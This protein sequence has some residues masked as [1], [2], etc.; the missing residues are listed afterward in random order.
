MGLRGMLRGVPDLVVVGEA[1]NG[2]AAQVLCRQLMPDVVLLDVRMPDMNGLEVTRLIRQQFPAIHVIIVSMYDSPDHLLQAIRAGAAGYL[3]KDAT[4]YELVTTI[5]QVLAGTL[6]ID[7]HVMGQLLRRADQQAT[8]QDR[9]VLDHLTKRE[10]EVWQLIAKG[11]TNREIAMALSLS[12]GTIKIHVE[13]I[14]AKLGVSD[15][16]QAAVRAV[17][18]GIWKAATAAVELDDPA[19]DR[20]GSQQGRI[21][22][23]PPNS[24]K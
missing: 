3:L 24:R 19:D 11:Q 4:Q 15:R 7:A 22:G 16:T 14:L 13:H 6:P 2:H 20:P 8:P 21:E 18:L 1:E 17:E 10:I 9:T 5:R 12:V 23:K